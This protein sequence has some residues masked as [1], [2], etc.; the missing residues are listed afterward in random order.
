MSCSGFHHK[1]SNITAWFLIYIFFTFSLLAQGSSVLFDLSDAYIVSGNWNTVSNYQAGL[2]VINAIDSD[3][4]E[5]SVAFNC[6]N[7]FAFYSSGGDPGV[8]AYPIEAGKDSFYLSSGDNYAKIIIGGLTAGESYDFRFF[9]S[10][11][12]SGPRALDITID[13]TTVY[14]DAAY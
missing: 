6:V 14:L 7:G 3:G 12:S 11:A 2:H 13:S 5:T 4:N 8:T 9:G 10:R 1:Y